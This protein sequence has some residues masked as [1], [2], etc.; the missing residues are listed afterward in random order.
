M[1]QVVQRGDRC[2]FLETFKYVLDEVL[3]NLYLVE[4]VP[5]HNSRVGLVHSNP[6]HFFRS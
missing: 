1:K 3:S 4:G 5:A 2:P 6:H